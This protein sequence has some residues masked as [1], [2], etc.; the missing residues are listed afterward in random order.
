M[1]T[2]V[3]IA[4]F[5]AAIA[6][7]LIAALVAR[8]GPQLVIAVLAAALLAAYGLRDVF[9]RERLRV[10]AGGLVVVNG[11]AQRHHLAW[12]D[13]ERLRVDSRSRFGARSQILEIDT[14][15]DLHLYSRFDL[16]VDPEHALAAIEELR[17]NRA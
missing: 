13:V 7:A 3:L 9:A 17:P 5:G 2:G 6:I 12:P 10:D 14:G 1:P 16:G 8:V 4:K 11:F 15:D